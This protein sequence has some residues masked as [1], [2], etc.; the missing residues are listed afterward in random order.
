MK[1]YIKNS[2]RIGFA[3][4]VSTGRIESVSLEVA[5][6]FEL[7]SSICD[8]RALP[9]FPVGVV[10]EIVSLCSDLEDLAPHYEMPAEYVDYVKENRD[11]LGYFERSEDSVKSEEVRIINKRKTFDIFRGMVEKGEEM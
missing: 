9:E 10:R 11:V 8:N 2:L 1:S 5:R 6:R 7:L 4:E 3:K